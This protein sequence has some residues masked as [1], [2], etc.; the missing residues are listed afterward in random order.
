MT[1]TIDAP[2]APV[3]GVTAAELAVMRAAAGAFHEQFAGGRDEYVWPWPE[4]PHSILRAHYFGKLA[5]PFIPPPGAA[6]CA[7]YMDT[8]PNVPHHYVPHAAGGHP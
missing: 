1:V 5:E 8:N 7:C 2:S 3:P 6:R 4:R